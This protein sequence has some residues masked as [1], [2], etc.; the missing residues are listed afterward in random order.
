MPPVADSVA[1]EACGKFITISNAAQAAL[2]FISI[3]DR[4]A[5]ELSSTATPIPPLAAGPRVHRNDFDKMHFVVHG[6]VVTALYTM[7]WYL[8]NSYSVPSTRRAA[9]AQWLEEKLLLPS[10]VLLTNLV[11]VPLDKEVEKQP[12]SPRTALKALEMQAKLIMET[13]LGWSQRD[14]ALN[15]N[16][17]NVN[18]VRNA[19]GYGTTR[20]TP[21]HLLHKL[22]RFCFD[23]DI[24][25][26]GRDLRIFHKH[27]ETITLQCGQHSILP[28]R[29]PTFRHD[30]SI[31]VPT[32]T[33]NFTLLILALYGWAQLGA[34]SDLTYGS[35][36]R[37]EILALHL[38]VC[39][40]EDTRL[41]E[42]ILDWALLRELA[43][44]R[45]YGCPLKQATKWIWESWEERWVAEAAHKLFA[46]YHMEKYP[47]VNG[48]PASVEGLVKSFG[49]SVG[50]A[51]EWLLKLYPPEGTSD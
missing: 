46:G 40:V 31:R 16:G 24:S 29:P 39:K 33:L 13:E 18:A 28:V 42:F 14:T 15:G 30:Y 32:P 49:Q 7:Q 8:N 17:I 1:A 21:P 25:H 5:T 4:A 38:F 10:G 51:T 22:C 2:L 23:T 3:L 43:T 47:E 50:T 35:L 11:V 34:D 48:R 27:S 44:D 20:D 36:L 45:F 37:V 41:P 26:P 12:S 6:P 9:E 19:L